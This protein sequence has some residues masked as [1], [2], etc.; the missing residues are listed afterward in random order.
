V[1]VRSEETLMF[2]W[3]GGRHASREPV[4]TREQAAAL[5]DDEIRLRGWDGFNLR[6]YRLE[7]QGRR[8]LWICRAVYGF[9]R[10]GGMTIEIDALTGD[11]VR[12]V[13]GC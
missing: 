12:A 6:S 7:Q 11:L 10:S 4:L 13:V 5:I 8:R 3:P 2:G 1:V 9:S